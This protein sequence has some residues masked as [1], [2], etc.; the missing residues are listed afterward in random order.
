MPAEKRYRDDAAFDHCAITPCPVVG[1]SC[2]SVMRPTARGVEVGA[3]PAAT[4]M[5]L[6]WNVSSSMKTRACRSLLVGQRG[7]ARRR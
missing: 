5:K 2:S 1:T 3:G 6:L 4:A 7:R